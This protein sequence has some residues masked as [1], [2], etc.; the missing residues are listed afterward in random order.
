MTDIEPT[1]PR[2]RPRKLIVI[3]TACA[4]AAG[5]VIGGGTVFA[6]TTVQ[7]QNEQRIAEAEAAAAEALRI[8]AVADAE[9][10][11]ATA[12]A[13]AESGR[14]LRASLEAHL[15]ADELASLDAAIADL[16]AATS[17]PV[18]KTWSKTA[19]TKAV[20]ASN[21]AGAGWGEAKAASL[22]ALRSKLTGILDGLG[23]AGADTVAAAQT[24]IAA[25]TDTADPSA[26]AAAWTALEAAK[27]SHTANTPPPPVAKPSTPKSGTG[28]KKDGHNSAP[29]GG[30]AMPTPYGVKDGVYWDDAK[31]A[32]QVA[33]THGL[34]QKGS[35][36]NC[37]HWRYVTWG[38][39]ETPPAPEWHSFALSA[40]K[41]VFTA[42][43]H[44]SGAKAEYLYCP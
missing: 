5:L 26:V 36:D 42:Y 19:S 4:L 8:D 11:H 1:A 39:T 29:N 18:V 38:G 9:D 31:A 22:A 3:A 2:A 30:F 44:G 17:T 12:K 28:A 7:Q 13:H 41:L 24:G 33:A 6:V 34:A 27:A 10:A 43:A 23:Y 21:K 35:G 14:E 37:H 16:D 40:T 15:T 20:A 32:S 25:L